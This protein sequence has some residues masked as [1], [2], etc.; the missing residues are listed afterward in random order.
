[1]G[2][3]PSAAMSMPLQMPP[4]FA[5]PP[6]VSAPPP[7]TFSSVPPSTD[8]SQSSY[9]RSATSKKARVM[10][11]I[12]RV[13]QQTPADRRPM[14]ITINNGLP[15]VLFDIGTELD[16]NCLTLVV[17]TAAGVNTGYKAYHKW[18]LQEHPELVH[19]YE[20]CDGQHPFDALRLQGALR[21]DDKRIKNDMRGHLT[22]VIRYHTPYT[23]TCGNP[24]LFSVALGDDVQVNTIMGYG[25]L[26]DLHSSID[27]VEQALICHSIR[28]SF[29]LTNQEAPF[30]L[31]PNAQVREQQLPITP[32]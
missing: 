22:A 21:E 25:M 19:S 28:Q 7:P 11:A 31:P 6:F 26:V 18:I 10:P 9:P 5:P 23:D 3:P 30:G 12:V 20:E 14:P 8:R 2:S 32:L 4:T 15:T 13:L 17:D 24:I 1:M 27:L 16:N 29:H